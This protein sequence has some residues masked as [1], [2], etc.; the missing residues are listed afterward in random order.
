M[1]QRLKHLIKR[2][3]GAIDQSLSRSESISEVIGEIRKEGYDVVLVLE[4]T[5]GF[6]KR[7]EQSSRTQSPVLTHEDLDSSL[8]EQDQQFLKALSIRLDD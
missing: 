1:E 4:A 5:I 3:G 7:Q 8:T 6:N 2:L